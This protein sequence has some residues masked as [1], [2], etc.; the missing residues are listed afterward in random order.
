MRKVICTHLVELRVVTVCIVVVLVIVPSCFGERAEPNRQSAD[1]HDDRNE[2]E[3]RRDAADHNAGDGHA[4]ALLA[5]FI[6]LHERDDRKHE[7][8]EREE[9]RADETGAADK[10]RRKT[11][12]S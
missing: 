7:A 5:G 12:S 1:D 3:R 10:R 4:S 8:N 2:S 6:D 11:D 9:E